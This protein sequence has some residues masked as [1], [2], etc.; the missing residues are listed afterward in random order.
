[1]AS[2]AQA[3]TYEAHDRAFQGRIPTPEHELLLC[4]AGPLAQREAHRDRAARLRQTVDVSTLIGQLQ[5]HRLEALLGG[6]ILALGSSPAPALVASVRRAADAGRRIAAAQELV[7]LGVLAALDAAEVRSVP[8]KGPLLAAALHGD[9]ALRVSTDIDVLVAP[10]DLAAAVQVVGSLGWTPRHAW[11]RAR[12]PL[13]HEEMGRAGTVP[14]VELHWRVHFYEREASAAMLRRAVKDP[15]AGWRLAPA[16]ELAMLILVWARDG[17]A[18]LRTPVDIAAWW[19]RHADATQQPVLGPFVRDHP[20]LRRAVVTAA[21]ILEDLV[22]VPARALVGDVPGLPRRSLIAR[23]LADPLLTLSDNQGIAEV[24]LMDAL[25]A[26]TSDL[27]RFLRRQVVLPADIA[28]ERFPESRSA[29]LASAG[30]AVR[31]VRRYALAVLPAPHAETP[32]LAAIRAV[33][34]GRRTA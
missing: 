32:T 34:D 26:P 21:T 7:T 30:H 22:G 24:S 27:P 20:R 13:L 15:A 2:D 1:M 9:A 4:V 14:G 33:I 5:R 3:R 31:V 29:A 10:E 12:M 18:G 16:D 23:R 8:L 25:V 28:R 17:F 11:P 19:D 6:R